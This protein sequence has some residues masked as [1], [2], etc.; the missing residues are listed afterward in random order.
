MSSLSKGIILHAFYIVNVGISKLKT[1][2]LYQLWILVLLF[3]HVKFTYTIVTLK[4]VFLL[5]G[6]LPLL[7]L[8]FYLYLHHVPVGDVIEKHCTNLSYNQADIALS[9][10]MISIDQQD[11]CL[12]SL[13]TH[14]KPTFCVIDLVSS[15]VCWEAVILTK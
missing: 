1:K 11:S 15:P 14:Y 12:T 4:S 13:N 9:E 2:Q 10:P 7:K 3:H 6:W 8:E 5:L